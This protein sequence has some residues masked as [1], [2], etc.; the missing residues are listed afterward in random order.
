MNTGVGCRFL[1][2]N[3]HQI[4]KYSKTEKEKNN[5]TEEH[6]EEKFYLRVTENFLD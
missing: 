2:Q 3:I 4:S 6:N 5:K 1:L